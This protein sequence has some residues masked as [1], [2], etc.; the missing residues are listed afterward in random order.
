MWSDWLVF[1]DYGFS[2]SAL[3]CPLPT[4][5]VLGFLTLN[6]KAQPLLL[7]LE[8]GCHVTAVPPDLEYGVAT[9][10]PPVPA[11]LWL[12]G[13]G[14]APLGHSPWPQTWG[15]SSRPPPLTLDVRLL[16]LS[17]APDLGHG[18]APLG[19]SCAVAAWS[20]PLLPLTLGVGMTSVQHWCFSL[21]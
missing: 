16:L 12:L 18:V 15:S 1:C 5:T 7:T 14:V 3:W 10:G 9:L 21:L 20:F 17:S 11:Q 4:P 8:E 6:V 2:V 19:R 13:H